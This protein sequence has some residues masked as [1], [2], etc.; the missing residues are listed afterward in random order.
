M[1]PCFSRT[2]IQIFA[3]ARRMIRL[4]PAAGIGAR[5]T[6]EAGDGNLVSGVVAG[7]NGVGSEGVFVTS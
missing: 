1:R 7:P 2:S 5:R 4:S 3:F 6:G